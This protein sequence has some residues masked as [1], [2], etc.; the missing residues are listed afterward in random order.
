MSEPPATIKFVILTSV[1]LLLGAEVTRD[2]VLT[3]RA[4][5]L[6]IVVVVAA[7]LATGVA[8]A[9]VLR[10]LGVDPATAVLASS[11]G[12]LTQMSALSSDTGASLPLVVTAHLARVIG[13]LLAT[14]LILKLTS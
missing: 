12:G 2:S 1:G 14:P 10:Q 3:L 4:H 13:V 6:P 9:F 11:P 5:T 7:L 8:V